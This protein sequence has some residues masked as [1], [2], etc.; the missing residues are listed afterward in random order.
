MSNLQRE[1]K[2][3]NQRIRTLEYQSI[4]A[5]ARSR[6][7]NI[8]IRGIEETAISENC[9]ALVKTF[10]AEH[11]SIESS[12]MCIQRAHRLGTPTRS[13]SRPIIVC[14]RDYP[15]TELIISSAYKLKGKPNFS[16]SRDYPREIAEAR[17]RL[18][19]KYKE[20]KASNPAR[21]V[22]I[23]YPAKLILKGQT[24]LDEFPDW[25]TVLDKSR[26]NPEQPFS[27]PRHIDKPH[28]PDV[29]TSNRFD[30]LTEHDPPTCDNSSSNE[31]ES[32]DS[33]QNTD[34]YSQV[35]M[36]FESRNTKH[37]QG[38]PVEAQSPNVSHQ[39]TIKDAPLNLSQNHNH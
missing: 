25:G 12:S 32:D 8:I 22:R 1:C 31:S 18:W 23:G 28:Y 2:A 9:T 16:I 17:S 7:N 14:F 15:D 5:E 33:Q 13:K 27:K 3:S 21:T 37:K 30:I 26:H 11:L 29:T 10:L 4:N 6:R 39:G 20:L 38:K 19:P 35:M 34:Q 24:V 36:E